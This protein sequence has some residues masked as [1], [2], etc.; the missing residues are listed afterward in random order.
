[1]QLSDTRHMPT[2]RQALYALVA[3]SS[4]ILAILSATLLAYQL[5]WTIG[6]NKPV[7]ALLV[8]AI[9]TTAHCTFFLSPVRATSP[10]KRRGLASLQVELLSL[11]VFD[12]FTLACTARLHS[13]TPGLL[14]TCGGYFV[15]SALQ[16]C[17]SL[18]WISFLFLTLLFASLLTATLYHRR[19]S[20]YISVFRQPFA[21]VDWS[22]YA[23]HAVRLPGPGRLAAEGAGAA[24]GSFQSERAEGVKR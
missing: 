22:M 12:L 2:L 4:V 10:P 8:C 7:P 16:G 17:Y 24:R 14:T 11:A 9:L 21:L 20:P 19:R 6:Y 15:C 5:R 3:V 18:A 13:S 23:T 1:M